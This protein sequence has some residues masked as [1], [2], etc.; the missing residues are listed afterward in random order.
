MVSPVAVC[1]LLMPL[2]AATVQVATATDQAMPVRC[3]VELDIFSGEPN[4][5]WA[6]TDAE[7]DSFARQLAALP[8]TASR[9]LSGRLG[10]RGFIVHC[11][12]GGAAWSVRLQNGVAH[13]AR[14][15]STWAED[16]QRR[17]ER[18][19]LGTGKP[20]LKPDLYAFAEKELR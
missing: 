15:A 3:D 18:W 1:A 17:L 2:C 20:H 16:G 10:Y 8:S 7:A 13:I 4:P 11:T 6:M 19:L 12:E 9:Q 14:G 5:V